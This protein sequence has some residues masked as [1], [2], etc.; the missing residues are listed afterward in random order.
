LAPANGVGM[1]IRQAHNVAVTYCHAGCPVIILTDDN[2]VAFAE[3]HI[4]LGQIETFVA[5]L[6][7]AA[8]NG[9]AILRPPA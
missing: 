1:S 6:R 9:E 8:A 7:E 4:P 3:V 5:L 2:N